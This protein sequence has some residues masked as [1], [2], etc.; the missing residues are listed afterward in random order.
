MKKREAK[1]QIDQEQGILP[2]SKIGA[3]LRDER[4]DPVQRPH[5]HHPTPKV[6]PNPEGY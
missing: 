2:W 1:R 5:L 3:S 4:Q 6:F